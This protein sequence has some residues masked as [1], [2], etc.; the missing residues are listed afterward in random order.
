G[1]DNVSFLA[2]KGD[3]TFAAPVNY[4]VGHTPTSLAVGT[5]TGVGGLPDVLV[6]LAGEK[7]ATILEP[8]RT[9]AFQFRTSTVDLGVKD[10]ALVA[11][12]DVD[13]DGRLDIVAAQ[14]K[15][16]TKA[17]TIRVL[18]GM[19]GFPNPKAFPLS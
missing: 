4:D 13:G 5:V 2:G 19:G 14:D 10:T 6:G 12:T 18:R 11:A 15:D 8:D 3:G 7:F 17:V 1:S 16:A 9:G